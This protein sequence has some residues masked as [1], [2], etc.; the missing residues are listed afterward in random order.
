MT[1][2]GVPGDGLYMFTYGNCQC[3]LT[4]T[5]TMIQNAAQYPIR[6]PCPTMF[7]GSA[8]PGILKIERAADVLTLTVATAGVGNVQPSGFEWKL[9]KVM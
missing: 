8:Y 2:T 4:L 3:F 6:C 9:I 1:Q 7:N 5:S